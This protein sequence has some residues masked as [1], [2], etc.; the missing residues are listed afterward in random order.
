MITHVIVATRPATPRSTKPARAARIR[1]VLVGLLLGLLGLMAMP[2]TP[3]AAH[4]ALVGSSPGQGSV[5]AQAPS[6]VV[7]TFTEGVTPVTGKVHVIAPDGSQADT[8][9]PRASGDQLIIPLKPNGPQGTFL[10]NY[11]VL[12]A[13]SHPVGGAF[14]YS[15]GAASPGGP[16]SAN[17]GDQAAN[18]VIRAAFP[19]ARWIGYV[20]LLLLVGAI[21]VLALLWP[22]RLD[23]RDPIRVIWLGAGLITLATVL[24]VLLQVPYVAGGG[25]SDFRA[26]DVREVLASQY[27][28]AHLIRLGV[29]AA[30]L[31]LSRPIARGR[32]WGADRVLLAVLGAIGVATW[33]VSGHPSASAVP[34]TT[35]VADMI[36]IGAMGVWLG[37][38]VMLVMFLLPRSSARE[39]AAII[40]IWSRWAT[41]AVS[42]LVL[43]GVAQALIEVGDLSK[44][45]TTTYGWLLLVKIG[46]VGIVIAVATQ[47]RRLVPVI[48][49]GTVAAPARELVPGIASSVDGSDGGYRT[50]AN[51]AGEDRAGDPGVPARERDAVRGLRRLIVAEAAVAAV[52]LG[53]TSVLVQTTPARSAVAQAITPAVQST[54]MKDKLYTL[55][56]D[57]QPATVG[58]NEVHLYASTPDGQSIDI[59]EWKVRASLPDQGIEPID[60]NVLPVTPSHAIGQ[61]GIPRAGSWTFTFTLRTTEIDQST[62]TARVVVQP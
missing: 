10:V 8:G 28:A 16:P 29:L 33:S 32:S 35:V 20:G 4:A 37:G 51:W 62:V 23:R 43:T 56:V 27:G 55:T 13:D 59:K 3:A 52:V 24:E 7:L 53:V 40:P 1:T 34:M 9:D 42:A 49:A 46:L 44:L 30:A 18:P 25:L 12:S 5:V 50:D 31:V 19:V 21:A 57:V 15:V 41:Y 36:H 61:I 11:R 54:T 39:L 47:S 26:A 6:Q 45:L 2:A 60:A 14:I 22:K 17:A 38:L 58:L 48:A